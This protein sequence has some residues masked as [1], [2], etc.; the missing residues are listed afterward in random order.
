MSKKVLQ[1][2]WIAIGLSDCVRAL[3]EGDNLACL[4]WWNYKEI[5]STKQVKPPMKIWTL[6]KNDGGKLINL[7]I[8]LLVLFIIILLIDVLTESIWL[9]WELG[10]ILVNCTL[11][12][13]L[14]KH[15]DPSYWLEWHLLLYLLNMMASCNKLCKNEV[16]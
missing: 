9:N 5:E 3:P 13:M 2:C 4:H 15:I 16:G 8:D 12:K 10:K 7:L 6:M 1:C 11:L 14:E